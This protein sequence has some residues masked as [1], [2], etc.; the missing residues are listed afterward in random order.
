MFL[1][2]SAAGQAGGTQKVVRGHRG[3]LCHRYCI[4]YSQH[5]I[6]SPR[7]LRVGNCIKYSVGMIDI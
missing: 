2:D 1:S 4:K 3:G 6:D 5:S 7:L